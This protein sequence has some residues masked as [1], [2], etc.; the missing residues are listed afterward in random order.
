MNDSTEPKDRASNL[1]LA[2]S[3]AALRVPQ[4]ETATAMPQAK[5]VPVIMITMTSP[6]RFTNRELSWLAFNERVLEEADN[7]DHPLFERL[8]FLSITANNLNEFYMVRVAGLKGQIDAGVD[9]ASQEGLTSKQQLA[10]IRDRADTLMTAKQDCWRRL[11][12]ELADEGIVVIQEASELGKD[13]I[14]WL[15]QYFSDRLFP[16]LTPI[17]IDPAH[18]FPFLPN[19]GFAMVLALK[20]KRERDTLN[21]LVPLP[22]MIDRFI[23]LP[24]PGIRYIT[25]ENIVALHCCCSAVMSTMF[26]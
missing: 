22:Q 17:A 12:R 24:G 1:T 9:V 18:P 7:Q 15:E 14:A 26:A 4:A 5:A 2:E 8:R 13:D 23:L 20:R 16:V 25:L 10:L 6:E 3:R 11:K 19:L 21:A